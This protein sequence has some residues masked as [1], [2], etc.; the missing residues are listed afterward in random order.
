MSNKFSGFRQL[1]FKQISRYYGNAQLIPL[2][3][4]FLDHQTLLSPVVIFGAS[5]NCI[6][7]S[8]VLSLHHCAHL[9]N[10][11]SWN[12]A[13]WHNETVTEGQGQWRK[14]AVLGQE[15]INTPCYTQLDAKKAHIMTDI[16]GRYCLVGQSK[17][18]STAYKNMRLATFAPE[19]A[20]LT[21]YCLRVYCVDDTK[22]ALEVSTCH[23]YVF[24]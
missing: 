2:F 12:I 3:Y 14:M 13:V 7:K 10:S 21:E 22:D 19:N 11:S 9:S 23:I 8:A 20:N 16:P 4:P 5:E 18:N 15:T 1:S 6:G 24:P 17:P